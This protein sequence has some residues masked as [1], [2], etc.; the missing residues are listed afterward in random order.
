[1]KS[2]VNEPQV[3]LFRGWTNE[4]DRRISDRGLESELK[5]SLHNRIS[6]PIVASGQDDYFKSESAVFQSLC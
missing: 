6:L 2:I 4:R 1:M 3:S 5:D